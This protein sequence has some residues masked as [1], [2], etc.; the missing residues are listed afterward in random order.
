M[1]NKNVNI[2]STQQ[3]V[4]QPDNLFDT[5]LML[6][7]PSGQSTLWDDYSS[8][9]SVVEIIID[10][11]GRSP[12]EIAEE[13]E[14]LDREGL[15]YLEH[16][17]DLDDV[18]DMDDLDDMDL[19]DIDIPPRPLT[20]ADLDLDM[21]H[22]FDEDEHVEHEYE[23]DSD[24]ESEYAQREEYDTTQDD[25]DED[26]AE[27]AR[28]I[29]QYHSRNRGERRGKRNTASNAHTLS[30]YHREIGFFDLYT[31][32]ATTTYEFEPIG[33]FAL[34]VM[35]H[36]VGKAKQLYSN[37]NDD[38][39]EIEMLYEMSIALSPNNSP[40]FMDYAEGQE[41]YHKN[42]DKAE[43]FYIRAIEDYD[44]TRAMFNLADMFLRMYADND[45]DT[46]I[47][48][49]SVKDPTYIDSAIKYLKMAATFGDTYS[50]E[51][52]CALLYTHRPDEVE[53]FAVYFELLSIDHWP[54]ASLFENGDTRDYYNWRQVHKV[55]T[56]FTT[57][58]NPINVYE[59][60]KTFV[61]E[62]E[63]VG[64]GAVVDTSRRCLTNIVNNYRQVAPYITKV[65]LFTRL[66]NVV[67]CGVC[68]DEKLNI[69][70]QCGH[71]VC[72][73]CYKHVYLT[74]CPFC[75]FEFDTS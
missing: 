48:T 67:E 35:Y 32:T 71:I 44:D 63:S 6:A 21:G 7:D 10:R 18:D 69:D 50:Q 13:T 42:Y 22:V 47:I 60:L 64:A 14:R 17:N 58:I 34:A 62:A 25:I 40:C 43:K 45:D 49:E 75:R 33:L 61:Q 66:N 2:I 20:L 9:D 54:S 38:E 27:V 23:I 51:S 55:V 72:T 37:D 28:Q 19:V 65:A 39:R 56:D 31:T 11:T 3:Q 73:D 29:H 68:Y 4:H 52:A 16:G 36:V 57:N 30:T 26:R 46:A 41:M 53:E 74:N 24:D 59:R 70:L 8:D 12:A 5:G 1:S 15:H